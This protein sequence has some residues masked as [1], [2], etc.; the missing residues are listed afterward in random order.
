M[1]ARFLADGS[2]D[3][4]W[5]GYGYVE[6]EIEETGRSVGNDIV[7]HPKLGG[8]LVVGKHSLP[9]EFTRNLVMGLT[10]SGSLEPAF[11]GP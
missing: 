7:E 1:T 9:S 5:G 6:H 11:S 8:Y 4:T 2:L 10:S 3:S